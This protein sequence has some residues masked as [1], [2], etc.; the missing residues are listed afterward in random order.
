MKKKTRFKLKNDLAFIIETINKQN[1]Y[2]SLDKTLCEERVFVNKDRNIKL[3]FTGVI[4]KLMYKEI[5]GYNYVV[6]VDYKTGSPN[7]NLNNSYYGINMQL[8]IYVYLAKHKIDNV[9]IIGFYL[10][11]IVHKKPNKDSKKDLLTLKKDELKLE[12]YTNTNLNYVSLFDSNL[13]D[14]EVIKG[15]KTTK[16]GSIDSKTHTL[17]DFE[18]N[19][20]VKMTDDKVNE[21]F[22]KILDRDFSINPKI[23]DNENIGCKYCKYQDICFKN[24]DNNIY[25]DKMDYK[26][27]LKEG[28]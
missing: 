16:S 5:D 23:I 3:T 21:A 17:S 1:S 12:G 4:D 28:D 27:F 7:T 10:Q 13:D 24:E 26:E 20:L 18:I 9:R 15:F 25:L 22:T 6:I 14:S 8:P 19:N 11:K 2:S